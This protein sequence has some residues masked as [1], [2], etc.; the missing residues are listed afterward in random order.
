ML[1]QALNDQNQV[2]IDE[3]LAADGVKDWINRCVLL[4]QLD[5]SIRQFKDVK[6]ITCLAFA[7]LV[8]EARTVQQL[9]EAGA[10]VA[11]T[12]SRGSGQEVYSTVHYAC[13]SDV[14]S[15][16]KLEYLMHGEALSH[17]AAG[18][19]Q[20]VALGPELYS[21]ALRLA[22]RLNQAGRVKE[23]IDDHGASVNETDWWGRTAL[24]AAAET[25]SSEAINVLLQQ[26]DCRV[27]A[28]Y[29]WRRTALHLA[30]QAGHAEA[31]NVLVL[32]PDCRADATDGDD[33]TALH[34]AAEAG[35]A[36]V[37]NILVQHPN[38]R[39]NATDIRGSTALHLAAA[40][41]H[42]EAVNVL[43]QHSS[44]DISITDQDGLTAADLARRCGHDDIALLI[45]AISKGNF[46]KDF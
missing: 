44:A 45:E 16:I 46:E 30:A 31:I 34:A 37:V 22:V 26:T 39:V 9:V 14:D 24:H 8:N 18:G 3:H 27:N 6:S 36:E 4:K 41:G 5:N 20:R 17:R 12:D 40:A 7:S 19:S 1:L 10:D 15:D 25:G 13:A 43:V 2:A 32:H 29:E 23:L 21:T 33:R 35:S 38:C 42:A 11:V 28:T